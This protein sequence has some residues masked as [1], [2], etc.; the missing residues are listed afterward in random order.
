MHLSRSAKSST[1]PRGNSAATAPLPVLSERGC[2]AVLSPMGVPCLAGPS[3]VILYSF[4]YASWYL[5]RWC[6]VAQAHIHIDLQIS[7]EGES[8]ASLPASGKNEK[9]NP[10]A[11]KAK[12]FPETCSG[13]GP[14]SEA[15]D[16]I[17]V[18]QDEAVRPFPSVSPS[19][20][21][22]VSLWASQVMTS[23]A[24]YV[25][26]P[27]PKCSQGVSQAALLASHKG[28]EEAHIPWTHFLSH[29]YVQVHAC[30]FM[31][32]CSSLGRC[33]T[34]LRSYI[35]M[36]PYIDMYGM[37]FSVFMLCMYTYIY[38]YIGM[39]MCIYPYAFSCVLGSAFSSDCN[40]SGLE[41]NDVPAKCRV[42]PPLCSDC[43]CFH[44]F[45]NHLLLICG[46]RF[47]WWI[48]VK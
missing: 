28:F 5:W 38:L 40:V 29:K 13:S 35:Y 33:V 37:Y 22:T 27:R 26:I 46:R 31:S 19:L 17:P 18:Q 48:C 41:M 25:I 12:A 43:F 36:Y 3:D 44:S 6:S 32:S 39:R 14:S 1:S 15:A 11:S 45:I 34:S 4:C 47:W 10:F 24:V 23:P 21:Q 2:G 16:G 30:L 7:K 20:Q 42:V 8:T 9:E